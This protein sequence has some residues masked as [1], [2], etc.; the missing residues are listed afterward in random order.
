MVYIEVKNRGYQ[1]LDSIIRIGYYRFW[2]RNNESESLMT[3]LIVILGG[4]R[5][6]TW[7]VLAA[8]LSQGEGNRICGTSLLACSLTIVAKMMPCEISDG[9]AGVLE[10]CGFLFVSMGGRKREKKEALEK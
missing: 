3:P 7:R 10:L 4:G 8:S 9:F 2:Q 1:P 5:G 6:F